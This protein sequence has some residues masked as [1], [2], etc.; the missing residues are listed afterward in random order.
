MT[1]KNA[2][3]T[4]PPSLSSLKTAKL[5]QSRFDFALLLRTGWL[6]RRVESWEYVGDAQWRVKLSL[7][8]NSD[9]VRKYYRETILGCASCRGGAANPRIINIPILNIRKSAQFADFSVSDKNG[10]PINL[11][12][13]EMGCHVAFSQLEGAILILHGDQASAYREQQL[14]PL[15]QKPE[16]SKFLVSLFKEPIPPTGKDDKVIEFGEPGT[17]EQVREHIENSIKEDLPKD[18]EWRGSS[19]DSLEEDF[20]EYWEHSR[21]FRYLVSLNVLRWLACAKVDLDKD[22]FS[23]VKMSFLAVRNTTEEVKKSPFERSRESGKVSLDVDLDG[24]G[25]GE[26]YHIL[27][28]APSG[29]QFTPCKLRE[30]EEQGDS[31]IKAR[32]LQSEPVSEIRTFFGLLKRKTPEYRFF[33]VKSLLE[34]NEDDKDELKFSPEAVAV[35]SL[36]PACATVKVQ[37]GWSSK[38]IDNDRES[39]GD[40]LYRRIPIHDSHAS[41]YRMCLNLAPKLGARSLGYLAYFALSVFVTLAIFSEY[42]SLMDGSGGLSISTLLLMLA[43][44]VAAVLIGLKE[45]PFVSR[46]VFRVPFR[47]GVACAILNVLV[48][49]IATVGGTEALDLDVP[50]ALLLAAIPNSMILIVY[51]CW[52]FWWHRKSKWTSAPDSFNVSEISIYPDLNGQ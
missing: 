2:A 23:M 13:R 33:V 20:N 6:H 45:E 15:S 5:N 41:V 28:H 44:I 22:D 19:I 30:P 49:G 25:V 10:R 27:V 29:T 46:R 7:D 26:V 18:P 51:G 14:P 3:L 21:V 24:V 52:F 39:K 12:L 35:G 32:I 4:V 9:E 40:H 37:M 43:P 17:Y 8:I 31:G 1:N 47:L 48:L 34:R 16:L 42:H 38:P 36:T 11:L 50:K